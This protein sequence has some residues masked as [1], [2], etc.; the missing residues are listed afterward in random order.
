MPSAIPSTTAP[1]AAGATL[2]IG[3]A[4]VLAAAPAA[5][6]QSTSSFIRGT[7][8][9]QNGMPIQGV[10][11]VARS[12]TQIGGPKTAY[13]DA[14]GGFRI[15][16]LL[17]GVFEVEA[18]APNLRSVVKE[19][20][21]LS[22]NAPADLTFMMEVQTRAEEVKV[23]EKAPVISTTA[24]NVKET[25]TKEFIEE[26]PLTTPSY[27][28]VAD[29]AVGWNASKKDFR[30]R[31]GNVYDNNFMV[32]GF[33]ISDPVT[34]GTAQF[35]NFDAIAAVEVQ[36][37]AYG[38]EN[39]NAQGGVLNVV[40]KTGS[41]KY[42][43][44]L[45]GRYT[46]DNLQFWRDALDVDAP[47]RNAYANASLGGPVVRDR[48]WFFVSS[49]NQIDV[50][51]LG[52][53]P[54]GQ[55][56]RE[57]PSKNYRAHRLLGKVTWQAAPRHKLSLLG[58]WT[59][60]RTENASQRFQTAPEAE[61][62]SGAFA[63]VTWHAIVTD[64]LVYRLQAGVNRMA[65]ESE[66]Q[67]CRTEPGT[68]FET[69]TVRERTGN[70]RL[71]NWNLAERSVGETLQ[72][73][74][75]LEW[76]KDDALGDHRAK[77]GFRA[78][79]N[80]NPYRVRTPGDRELILLA[81]AP[82]RQRTF[83]AEDPAAT[84]GL[85]RQGWFET[86]VTGETGSVFLQDAWRPTPHLTLTPGAALNYGNHR[87]PEGRSVITIV[88]PTPH[89]AAVWDATHDGKTAVRASAA[90]YVD[91]G[92]LG[93]ARYAARTPYYEECRWD[94][95]TSS[96]SRQCR[97]AGGLGRST[98]NKPCGP[99]PVGKHGEPCAI[100]GATPRTWELTIGAEREV[101]SGVAFGA[102]FIYR[103]YNDQWQD[104]EVNRVWNESGTALHP[105]G[106]YKNGRNET[107]QDLSPR[108]EN[109]RRYDGLTVFARK[110]EGRFRALIAWTRHTQF[111]APLGYTGD[112][113]TNPA[114]TPYHYGYLETDQRNEAKFMGNYAL[115]SWLTLGFNVIYR[116]N[117]PR[118]RWYYN[119]V[120]AGYDD[121][122]AS[123]GFDPRN[124]NDADDDVLIR[125]DDSFLAFL[126]VRFKLRRL[127]GQDL[128]L[129]ADAY[130]IAGNREY[131]GFVEEDLPTWGLPTKRRGAPYMRFGAR[132]RY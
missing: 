126:Q 131:Q 72:V 57:H 30:V 51:N 113:L 123:Y 12:A 9:D 24:A 92:F 56:A 85:C 39:G 118:N 6:A 25:F 46:D 5:R 119:T 13:T 71:G 27:Q 107:I 98:I 96:Y 68:C 41:N 11:V 125:E 111:G 124:P 34:R 32:D 100:E 103:R 87:D 52:R 101:I 70:L 19:G 116:N 130:N 40:T 104:A 48:L 38:A 62:L 97:F 86:M 20:V 10:R 14:E 15:L 94:E 36:A 121:L 127:V 64:S 112:F 105:D 31:G 21:E 79:F 37:A 114:Q 47:T 7:V 91:T 50:T 66:P 59:P 115:F 4:V 8:I 2:A 28:N 102:D 80:R 35:I 44:E 108:P 65:L 89:L 81:G 120:T 122:R 58:L 109:W 75:D 33:Q 55:F 73:N 90:S 82:D 106:G 1:R 93:L 42:Q 16:G 69:A 128:D 129:W 61:Q 74:S 76:F 67:R 54:S 3:L 77:L 84:G 29:Q 132:Y 88:A 49:E 43:L 110:Y 23:V 78:N 17:P 26:V 95:A 117:Q 63:G 53:D 45:S 83:C 18:S 60:E 22:I 99:V